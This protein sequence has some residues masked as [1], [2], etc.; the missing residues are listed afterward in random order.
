M[1]NVVKLKKGLDINLKGTQ[2]ETCLEPLQAATYLMIPD[3]FNVMIPK[4]IVHASD[5][6]LW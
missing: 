4:F 5:K 6:L 2:Q 1:T 3:N